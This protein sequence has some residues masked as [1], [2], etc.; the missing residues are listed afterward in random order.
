MVSGV[1]VVMVFLEWARFASGND[2]A[3]VILQVLE[4]VPNKGAICFVPAKMLQ[5]LV[6]SPWKAVFVCRGDVERVKH[7]Y[8]LEC[9]LAPTATLLIQAIR[10]SG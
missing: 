7:G 8:P 10:R 9:G 1:G 2:L 5:K 6:F 4:R 3:R